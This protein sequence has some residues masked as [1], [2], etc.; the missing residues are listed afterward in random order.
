M[1]TLRELRWEIQQQIHQLTSTSRTDILHSLAQSCKDDVTGEAPSRDA[2]AVEF[3]DF[4][5]D[6]LRSEG[7]RALEDQGM[8]ALLVF[9]DLINDLQG[10]QEPV[11]GGAQ[12][13][14]KTTAE[15]VAETEPLKTNTNPSM[16]T[17]TNTTSI[18]ATPAVA[19]KV[20]GLV[21]LTEVAAML[22]RREYK[23]H[24]GQISDSD[25]DFNFNH[26]SKQID[27]GLAEGFTEAEIIRTVFKLIKPG[28]F[29]DMLTT[30]QSLTVAELK[31]FLRAH[32][33]DKSS[34]ELF[35][36]LSNAKQLDKEGP[37]QFMYR[38]MGL[39]QRLLFASKQT[40][41]F[42]YDGTLVQGVFLH[43]LYQGMN[44]RY[45]HVRRDIRPHI[46]NMKVTDD[47]ILDTIT[48]S[49]S[50]DIE[51]QNRLGH[52]NK[53]R[54]ANIN[55]VQQNSGQQKDDQMQTELQ[56]NRTAIHELT[57][58]VSS[59]TKSLEKAFTKTPE[60]IGTTPT[61]AKSSPKSDVRGKCQQ[62]ITQGNDCCTHCFRCGGEGHR[63]IGCLRKNSQSGNQQR[64]LGRD[65][66]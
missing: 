27:E 57:A 14:E 44:E 40:A 38:L 19:E 54:Q 2:T 11:N 24:G 66:Q 26:L 47:F 25:S 39:K 5:Q 43:S 6:F 32:I 1:T 35:Q 13:S 63:A 64:P 37:Q 17:N 12:A 59:L 23:I 51:R 50:E 45:A 10:G 16:D 61:R 22:P 18:P 46:S 62:C 52:A 60:N 58:Q 41:G 30:K 34:T 65:H 28:T 36:E 29:R 21:K 42:Q 15:A 55:A 33:R 4:L 48:R 56:A 8:A 3:F 53:Q 31:S 7:L 20:P 9:R 49:V